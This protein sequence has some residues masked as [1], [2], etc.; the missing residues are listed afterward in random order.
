MK[1]TKINQETGEPA[2]K[3]CNSF[4]PHDYTSGNFRIVNNSFSLRKNAW[5]LTKNNA[6]INK[7]NSLKQAKQFAE[8]LE[9]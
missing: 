8:S 3:N 2:Q 6:E 9:G 4:M 7:F 1:W 5:T